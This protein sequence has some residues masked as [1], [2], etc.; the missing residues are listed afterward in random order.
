MSRPTL[1]LFDIDDTLVS[2]AGAGRRALHAA[3]CDLLGE[4]DWLPFTLAGMTDRSIV[5][6]ALREAGHADGEAVIDRVLQRYLERLVGE[7]AHAEGYAVFPGVEQVLDALAQTPRRCAVGLGTG[8]LEQG[9][10]IKL[11]RGGLDGRFAFG[12]FGS[13]HEV[14]AEILRAGARR[15]ALHLGEPVERCRVVAIG[16]TPR[17]VEAALAIGAECIGVGTGAHSP[18]EL[19]AAGAFAAFADLTAPGALAAL[20]GEV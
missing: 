13:D 8:N 19:R 15:G 17:D 5:R 14:R 4:R 9:A 12:G 18:E 10:R 6:R 3:F 7:V 11:A 16:D 2:T 20:L 1:F